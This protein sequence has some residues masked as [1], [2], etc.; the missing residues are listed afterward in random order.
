MKDET[1]HEISS[2]IVKKWNQEGADR[3]GRRT[4]EQKTGDYHK[5]KAGGIS[6]PY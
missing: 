3:L 2:A 5:E 4:Q 6:N 1:Y